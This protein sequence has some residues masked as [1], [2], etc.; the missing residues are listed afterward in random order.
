MNRIFFLIGR[1]K[2]K[3]ISQALRLRQAK[4]RME[5]SNFFID[6]DN[7][8]NANLVQELNLEVECFYRTL[9]N[10]LESLVL[11]WREAS[12]RVVK[13]GKA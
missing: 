3:N 12:G 4:L 6:S 13:G 10:C 8:I 9:Y 2:P 5:Q 7:K 11:F 1:I